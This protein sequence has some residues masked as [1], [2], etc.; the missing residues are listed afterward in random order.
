MI[1]CWCGEFAIANTSPDQQSGNIILL[2][3][4]WCKKGVKINSVDKDEHRSTVKACEK[5]MS[6]GRDGGAVARYEIDVLKYLLRRS[7][8]F[9]DEYKSDADK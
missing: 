2:K 5:N 7:M 4:R 3:G 9:L 1:L 8:N 6:S